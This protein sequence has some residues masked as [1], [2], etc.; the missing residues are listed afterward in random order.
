MTYEEI[1]GELGRLVSLAESLQTDMMS[2]SAAN[3]LSSAISA[4]EEVLTGAKDFN[5]NVALTLNTAIAKATE[6]IKEY[7]NLQAAI[8][9]RRLLMIRNLFT[10]R[11]KKVRSISFQ[12]SL[13]PN[14]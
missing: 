5:T 13:K 3:G 8:D 10:T 6:S 7:Q 11:L 14:T 4:A 12:N 2:T 9:C 1:D